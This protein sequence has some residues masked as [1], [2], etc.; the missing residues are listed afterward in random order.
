[1]CNS[2]KN[3]GKEKFTLI[4]EDT[5]ETENGSGLAATVE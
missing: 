1:M 4:D 3:I 5:E 2:C